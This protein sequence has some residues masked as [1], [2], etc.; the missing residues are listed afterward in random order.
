MEAVFVVRLTVIHTY[1][2]GQCNSYHISSG[3]L[4]GVQVLSARSKTHKERGMCVLLSFTRMTEARTFELISQHHE[5][6]AS[7]GFHWKTST[8]NSEK[9]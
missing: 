1:D 4:Y 9:R 3:A 2:E 7:M 8:N 5:E 6:A